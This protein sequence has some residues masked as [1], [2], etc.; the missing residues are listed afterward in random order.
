MAYVNSAYPD[1]TDPEGT[2]WSWSVR[3]VAKYFE[4]QLHKKQRLGHKI[5]E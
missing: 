5:N 2:V 3:Q 1:Q 4:E